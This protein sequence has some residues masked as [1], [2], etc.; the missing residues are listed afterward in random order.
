MDVIDSLHKWTVKKIQK[1]KLKKT[2][3][4]YC[5]TWCKTT[6]APENTEE[7]FLVYKQESEF[8]VLTCSQCGGTSIWTNEAGFYFY[9]SHLDPPKPKFKPSSWAKMIE[10]K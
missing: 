6:V 1:R 2:G 3:M 7:N 9:I 5:C 10:N 8:F 4:V